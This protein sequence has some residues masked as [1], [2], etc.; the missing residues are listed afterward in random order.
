MRCRHCN[1]QIKNSDLYC[2]KCRKKTQSIKENF[3]IWNTLKESYLDEKEN[4]NYNFK[5]NLFFGG[6][7]FIFILLLGF[8]YF[9]FNYSSDWTRYLVE[10][11]I[12]LIFV[13]ILIVPFG[14]QNVVMEIG[15]GKELNNYIFKIFPKYIL[16]VLI[17]IAIFALI[18][19]LCIGDPVLRLVRVILVLW[20]LAVLLPMPVMI[21]KY[22]LNLYKLFK[23]SLRGFE[24][25]RWQMFFGYI[26][27]LLMHIAMIL[28]FF[29]GYLRFGN[30]TYISLNRYVEKV[31]ENEILDDYLK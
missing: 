11:S 26:L 1:A 6:I 4:E 17:N 12:F 10:N 5:F 2:P 31:D 14:I 25:L 23:L 16:F 22:N 15:Y 24:D 18:K 20:W 8:H 27:I 9:S 3:L 21:N 7:I 29:I 13:P 19:F 30:I 28:S